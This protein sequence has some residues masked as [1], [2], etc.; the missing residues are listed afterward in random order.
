MKNF[1]MSKN[2][3]KK[4]NIKF[5][6]NDNNKLE[7]SFS[8]F[9]EEERL[10]CQLELD[11]FKEKLREDV[12]I[13]KEGLLQEIENMKLVLADNKKQLDKDKESLDLSR[14]SLEADRQ[15]MTLEIQKLREEAEKEGKQK[16]YN[17]SKEKGYQTGL[18]EGRKQGEKEFD[19]IKKEYIN[20][21]KELFKKI[22]SLDTYKIKIFE[23]TEP[24]FI[25][26][27]EDVIK[28]ILVAE[29]DLNPEI[30]LSIIRNA[31]AKVGDNFKIEI[32]VSK[33]EYE[34]INENRDILIKELGP[35][36]S[37]KIVSSEDIHSGGCV[38]DTDFGLIDASIDSKLLSI[39]EVINNTL[40]NKQRIRNNS[41]SEEQLNIESDT[42]EENIEFSDE[43]GQDDDIF[44]DQGQDD[45]LTFD[46]DEL[47]FLDEDEDLFDT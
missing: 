47:D 7:H 26:L 33:S 27:L 9:S 22:Q 42:I 17:D 3:I 46:D 44:K 1:K 45:I 35:I 30:S 5:N 39:M 6:D 31:L 8:N 38:I 15:K 16:G 21:T 4:G 40:E 13:F 36:H 43:L 23:K 2:I 14:Q 34:F 11:I 28:K 24:F 18:Q 41:D 29:I 25:G 20:N 12:F 10:K 32:K 37:L 19:S